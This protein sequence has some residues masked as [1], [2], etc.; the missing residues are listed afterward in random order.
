[1]YNSLEFG[2]VSE[3][4]SWNPFYIY[5]SPFRDKWYCWES[6][7]QNWGRSVCCIL[8]IPFGKNNGSLILWN[9]K[10][11]C[12]M[13]ETSWQRSISTIYDSV[14]FFVRTPSHFC[15]K[16]IP[17]STNLVTKWDIEKLE[18]LD[19]SEVFARRLNAKEV[20]TPKSGEKLHFPNR[21]W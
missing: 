12:E 2:K 18:K 1:M 10:V 14:W 19:A 17:G 3:W 21:R 5:A 8:T 16:T 6:G 15:E 20:M 4:L 9:A 13:S 7:T 11:V